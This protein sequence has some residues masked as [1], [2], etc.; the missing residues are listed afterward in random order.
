MADNVVQ[1][2]TASTGELLSHLAEIQNDLAEAKAF[3]NLMGW[4]LPPGLDDVG[5]AT[6]DLGNFVQKLDAVTGAPN[7]VWE[8]EIAMLGRIAELTL[9]VTDLV[10]AIHALAEELP[11]KLAAFPDY[12]DRTNIHKELPRRLFDFLLTN[13]LARTSPVTYA[14][15]HLV[16]I[17]DY[18]YFAADPANFQAEH[19][20]ATVNYHHFKTLFKDPGKL[21]EEAYGWNTPNYDPTILLQRIQLLFQALGIRSRMQPL[22]SR[23]E[24][25]WT[26]QTS[27]NS[28]PMPQ[29]LTFLFEERGVIAGI[30]VG[31]SL[32]GARPTSTGG[33][34]GGIGMVPLIRGQVQGSIPLFRF[35]D[36]FLDFSGEADALKSIA[37]L[38]RPNK[39]LEVSTASGFNQAITGRFALGLRHGSPESELKTLLAFPGG[40]KIQFKTM[41]VTGGIENRSG[42]PQ[43]FMELSLLGCGIALSLSEADGFLRSS[44]SQ[45]KIAASF[46]IKIGWTSDGGI[47]FE[48]SGGLEISLATHIQLG[49]FH[50]D[51]LQLGLKAN[52]ENLVLEASVTGGLTLGPLKAVVDRIGLNVDLTFG[53]GNL[54]FIGLSPDFKPPNGIGLSIDTGIVKGGGFLFFDFDKGEYAGALELSIQNTI[55]VAA[56]GIINTKFPDG[57]QG[58]SL[59][60]IVAAQFTPGIALGMGFFLS[61]LGGMLGINRTINVPALRDGVKNNAIEHI[62]FPEDVVANINTLLP[63]IKL[64]FPIQR[65]QFMIGFMAKITWGVPALISIEFGLI[66]E[67]TNPVR[68]A[69]LG[70]LKIAL[71]TGEAAVLQLQVNFVGIIDF[72]KGY[73]SFDAS[74]YNSRILTFTLEGDMA[75]RLNWGSSKGFLMSVGGFHP[76]FKPPQELNVPKLKRLTLTILSGNPNLV[77]TSYFAITSNTVQFGAKIDFRFKKGSFSVV[78]YLQFDVLFQFSPFKFVCNISAGLE[79]KAGSSTLFSI[80][81]DFELSGPTPWNAKGTASFSILF[82]TFTI[83]FNVTWGDAQE[84]IE[85]GIAV[86]PKLLEAMNTDANWT[87]ELP[88]N[89][90]NLVTLANIQA[91]TGQIVMQAF[92]AMKISQTIMPLNIEI[93]KF[94]NSPLADIKFANVSA[95]RLGSSDMLLNEV[96]EVFAPSVFKEMSDDDKLK[97]PSYTQE[98]GGAKIADTNVLFVDYGFNRDVIY[99]VKISDFDPFPDPQPF[100]INMDMFKLMAKGGAIANSPLSKENTQKRFVLNNAAVDIAEEQF[101]IVNNATL[102]QHG[103]NE[104]AGGSQAQANDAL[105]FILAA[106]PALAGK[107]SIA[108]A[109]HV[110]A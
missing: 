41:S 13:Y 39:D 70:V 21:A 98:K 43:S 27:T 110:E 107:I 89:R 99:E 24:E 81:L 48:G 106:Q 6:I 44:I 91:Q 88:S 62:M 109:Y 54:G 16:N 25:V 108:S 12:V 100:E 68:I 96:K 3:I 29:L 22:D 15:L 14:V 93:N 38:L 58:F 46:D 7:E 63:Q 60:I 40:A 69:I 92:G 31:L 45:E 103:A 66:I 20:R 67:F 87:T 59:L 8:D 79:V 72:E 104:F 47:Y 52:D 32:F 77:L 83:R 9:A 105:Q 33:A 61:G 23:A 42:K 28:V 37:V 85:P 84:V 80:K 34:D 82:F 101:V 78:G 50:V 49:P 17:I 95:F 18:P 73:L 65:D 35:N 94:G 10:K 51:A 30:R 1:K 97:S 26:N 76:A 53:S 71:P 4:E 11:S 90:F 64:I 102:T 55:Q 75:L 5:L 2:I 86:L 56:V 57:T 19:I 36:T 74:L